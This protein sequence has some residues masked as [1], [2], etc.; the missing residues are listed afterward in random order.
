MAYK[1]FKSDNKEGG[2]LKALTPFLQ[3]ADQIPGVIFTFLIE[4]QIGS[5][6]EGDGINDLRNRI[7]ALTNW[8]DS[9]VEKLYRIQTFVGFLLAGLTRSDQSIYWITDEDAIVANPTYLA[10]ARDL[11]PRF[12]KTHF[13]HDLKL[14]DMGTVKLL[15]KNAPTGF[16]MDLAAIPDLV[17]GTLV[18]V[19]NARS[20][21]KVSNAH[22]Q[23]DGIPEKAQVIL[24]WFAQ[25]K[26]CLKKL[27]AVL[28]L[29][30]DAAKPLYFRWLKF[31]ML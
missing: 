2:R 1:K 29:S 12:S 21:L 23:M 13:K 26:H 30:G 6:I 7:P 27:A 24:G 4:K 31:S 18:D 10:I 20:K 15:E 5:V 11:L 19:W 22:I 16:A 14:I 25:P 3:A 17:G 28:E 8:A 9:N